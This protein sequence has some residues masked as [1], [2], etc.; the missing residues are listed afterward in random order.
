ML[1]PPK[2]A[3]IYSGHYWDTFPHAFPK[4]PI[5]PFWV[6]QTEKQ[7]QNQTNEQKRVMFI[8]FVQMCHI[9]N[10]EVCF[11]KN[12]SGLSISLTL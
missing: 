2:H 4:S 5:L 7:R 12:S 10:C 6:K 11:L 8:L 9:F 3:N 1:F